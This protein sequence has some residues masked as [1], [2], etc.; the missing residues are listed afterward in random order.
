MDDGNDDMGEA[1]REAYREE[2]DH[3]VRLL[4]RMADCTWTQDDHAWLSRFCNRNRLMSTEE[5]RARL[6]DCESAPLLMDGRRKTAN[7]QTDVADQVNAVILEKLSR[8][9]AVP[10]A[11][12]GAL[13]SAPEGVEAHKL[14]EAEFEGLASLFLVCVG[15][16]V[17]LTRNLWVDAGLMNGAASTV[18]VSFGRRAAIRRR[19]GRT[20]GCRSASSWSSTM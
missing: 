18:R 4:G 16:R 10:I 8:R 5:G 1:E 9:T 12:L 7:Q 3:F 6:A 19:S 15:A 14:D 13:H 11:G 20:S 2:A 17:L